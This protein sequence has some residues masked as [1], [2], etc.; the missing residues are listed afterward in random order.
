MW[1]ISGGEKNTDK[2]LITLQAVYILSAVLSVSWMLLLDPNTILGL[3]L[4]ILTALVDLLNVYLAYKFVHRS[5]QE[6]ESSRVKLV[7]YMVY[8][9][10]LSFILGQSSVSAILVSMFVVSYYYPLALSIQLGTGVFGCGLMTF[11]AVFY[12]SLRFPEIPVTLGYIW[13]HIVWGVNL[14]ML[15][16]K[17]GSLS[18]ADNEILLNSVLVSFIILLITVGLGLHRFITNIEKGYWNKVFFDEDKIEERVPLSPS[19]R[20]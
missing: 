6:Y 9:V 7:E 4:A 14:Y 17:K 3:V 11:I 10:P 16:G 5:E 19:A 1:Q 2:R 12:K 8:S 13:V 18:M 20:N 15:G